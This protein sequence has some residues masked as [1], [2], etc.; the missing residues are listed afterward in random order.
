MSIAHLR[1]RGQ[2]TL[3][4]SFR[5]QLQLE[6]DAALSLILIGQTVVMTPYE[7]RGEKLAK[8]FEREMKKKSLTL[9]DVLKDLKAIRRENNRQRYGL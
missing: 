4:A 1:G 8:K 3:P 5:R 6:D 2:I 9:E 7:A